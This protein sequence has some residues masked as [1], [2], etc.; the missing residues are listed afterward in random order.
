MFTVIVKGTNSCNLDCSYCSLGK[1]INGK[2]ADKNRLFDILEFGCKVAKDK[3]DP[4]VNFIFHGGEPTIISLD[5]YTYAIDRIENDYPEVKKEYSIQTNAWQLSEDYIEFLKKYNVKVGVSIDGSEY[6]HDTERRSKNGEKTFDRVCANIDRML[7]KEIPVSCLMVLTSVALKKDM[8]YLKFFEERNLHLKINPLLNYGEVY[9]HPE[10]SLSENEYADYLIR[11]Y[12]YIL[13]NSINV[14]ISPIDKILNAIL[15]DKKINECTFNANC[16]E[17][18][19][20]IDY[21]GNIYPCGKYSDLN[22]YKLGSIY[23]KSFSFHN[24]EILQKL[25]RRRTIN[26]PVECK[27]CK[28]IAMCNAGCNAEASIDG[29]IEK[30]PLLCSD[31]K[32]LFA[33]FIRDGLLLYKQKLEERRKELLKNGI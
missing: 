24:L 23:D 21:E 4:R 7:E 6:I 13:T 19:V 27:N 10:L 15:S 18:F 17:N 31:Y 3:V 1:K 2:I 29:N 22:E 20:C 8:D 11:L 32:K 16:N 14:S 9:V 12:E 5:S 33:Y 25:I 30:P 28:F 26:L